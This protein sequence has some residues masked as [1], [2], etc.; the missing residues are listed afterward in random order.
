MGVSMSTLQRMMLAFAVMVVIGAGQGLL[1]LSNLSSLG[2][3]VGYVATKPLVAVDNARAAWSTYRDA[4]A[5]LANFQEMTRP[6]DSKAALAAFDAHVVGLNAHLERLAGAV[7]SVAA[8]D[9]LKQARDDIARWADKGRILFGAVPGATSLPAPHSLAQAEVAIRAN[10]DDLVAFALADAD[11]VRA[12][13]DASLANATRLGLILVVVAVFAG[14]GLAIF[15][16]LAI[17]RPLRRLA[18]TMRALSEGRLNVVVADKERRDE[19][20]G[21]A[22]ALEVFRANAVEMRRLE[23]QSQETVRITAEERRKLL[24]DIADRFK[25]QMTGVVDRVL[26]TVAVIQMS[27]Q[28]MTEIADETRKRVDYVADESTAAAAS[29]ATVAA[30]AEEI[31]VVSSDISLKS[32]QSHHVA[33]EAVVKVATSAQVIASLTAATGKIGRIVDMIDDVAAQT[34]LLALNATIEAARAGAAGRG[35]AVVAA[36]V[37]TLAEQTA[38]ATSEIS[39]QIAQVQETTGRAAAVM[40]AIH[41]TMGTID[42]SS[43]EV[44]GAI[45]SQRLAIADIS[46]NT[47]SASASAT[48]VSANLQSLH[49]AF[50]AVALASGEIG[51]QVG[52]LGRNAQALRS[53]TEN[54]LADILAA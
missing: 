48:Q 16:G 43:A 6:Q 51:T 36:E 52:S 22:G 34:N 24:A 35:F 39:G 33:S 18:D 1:M 5:H 4:R 53:E 7:S 25:S 28:S 37:K 29:I 44:A 30:A 2:E 49:E 9:K 23:A 32:G 26:D 13:V 8:A 3:K 14:A 47:Q 54:F 42:A 17:S 27:A 12:D 46:Q 50:A 19:I 15:M 45:E 21:M 40:K 11:A 31:S 41:D 38:K 10:L 20:G